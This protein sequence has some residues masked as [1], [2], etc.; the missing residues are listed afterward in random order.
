[1]QTWIAGREKKGC[2]ESQANN[3]VPFKSRNSALKDPMKYFI[4][5]LGEI[6]S[7]RNRAVPINDSGS[8]GWKAPGCTHRYPALSVCAAGYPLSIQ[9]R[10]RRV[11]VWELLCSDPDKYYK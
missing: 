7:L 8:R 1:M 6:L 3:S 11:S 9:E 4:V 10:I 5:I 2:I